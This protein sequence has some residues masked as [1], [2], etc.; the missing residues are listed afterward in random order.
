MSHSQITL[1]CFL[2]V[3][4]NREAASSQLV[5]PLGTLLLPVYVVGEIMTGMGESKLFCFVS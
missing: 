5:S 2:V 1:Q 3:L 4:Q